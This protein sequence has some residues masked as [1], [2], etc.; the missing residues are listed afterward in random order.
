MAKKKTLYTPYQA[1]NDTGEKPRSFAVCDIEERPDP[2]TS[3]MERVKLYRDEENG[4]PQV[5]EFYSKTEDGFADK[6]NRQRLIYI[7]NK[8]PAAINFKGFGAKGDLHFTSVRRYKPDGEYEDGQYIN[9]FTYPDGTT[10]ERT[11][12]FVDGNAQGAASRIFYDAQGNK[13]S[14]RT[15]TYV[16]GNAQGLVKHYDGSGKLVAYQ[17]YSDGKM[18]SKIPYDQSLPVVMIE[19]CENMSDMAQFPAL[20]KRLLFRNAATELSQLIEL[21]TENGLIKGAQCANLA[22]GQALKLAA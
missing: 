20:N 12:A 22:V 9:N 7:A 4:D 10:S 5:I 1:L 19:A 8:N 13:T 18:V 3:K 11:L 2:V 17:L 21:M 15:F 14:E 6:P 16:D